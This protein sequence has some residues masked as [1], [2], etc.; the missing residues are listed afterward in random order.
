MLPNEVLLAAK[1]EVIHSI[2]SDL[3]IIFYKFINNSINA[4]YGFPVTTS[5]SI[6]SK[7]RSN[8]KIKD[9]NFF[10]L[11]L[12]CKNLLYIYIYKYI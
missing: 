6:N 1:S 5:I 7:S 2:N 9:R 10:A 12:R 3:R 11:S 4:I 8:M